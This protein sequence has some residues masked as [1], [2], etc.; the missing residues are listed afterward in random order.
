MPFSAW[1]QAIG[2]GLLALFGLGPPIYG[3]FAASA[4]LPRA[5]AGA[6]LLLLLLCEVALL[7]IFIPRLDLPGRSPHVGRRGRRR[8]AFTFDDGPNGA[9]TAQVL[10][11][12]RRHGARATFFCVG[13]AAAAQPDLVRRIAS[14]GHVIGN[15]TQD[16]RKLTL[17]PT[18]EIERQIDD[19]QRAIA[20]CGV[21]SPVWFRAPHGWKSPRLP[22]ILRRRSLHLCAWTHGV[23]DTDRPGVEVIVRR[24]RRHL[25]DGEILLLHDGGGDRRQT[26]AALDE[27]LHECRRRGLL[28]VTL[29]EI[30]AP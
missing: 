26:A 8:I 30:L 14:E 12:L 18:P 11:V 6:A 28:P 3:I 21:P 17:L 1:M 16:H 27:L 23:W 20:A 24:A 25:R 29:P 2:Y 22:A 15:H 13:S 19:A 7:W 4:P 5:L 9:D 10:D